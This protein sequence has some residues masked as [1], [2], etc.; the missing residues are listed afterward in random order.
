MKASSCA[1]AD[2]ELGLWVYSLVLSRSR[3][4]LPSANCQKRFCGP[5]LVET[6]GALNYRA[7]TSLGDAWRVANAGV[8]LVTRHLG[9]N[10]CDDNLGKHRGLPS[11]EVPEYSPDGWTAIFGYVCSKAM[12]WQTTATNVE[13]ALAGETPPDD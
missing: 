1:S 3:P 6:S 10:N 11:G 7:S 5:S 2:Q 13:R 9:S 8:E 12:T 4:P